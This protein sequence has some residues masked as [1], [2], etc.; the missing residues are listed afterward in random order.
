MAGL[1]LAG[2]EPLAPP[3]ADQTAGP[4]GRSVYCTVMADPVH[5]DKA[6]ETLIAPVHFRCDQPGPGTLR[7]AVGLQH[8]VGRVWVTVT[9]E[10]FTARGIETTRKRSEETRV[11]TV[12]APC[13]DGV[14]RSIVQAL[15]QTGP[16]ETRYEMNGVAVTNPCRRSSFDLG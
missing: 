8:K 16:L 3:L 10:E 11:R 12:T 7:L 15:A 13:A 4:A 9:A 5:P 2:C 6:R 1:L 14:Y